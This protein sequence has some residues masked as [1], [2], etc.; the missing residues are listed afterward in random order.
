MG[1]AQE[2]HSWTGHQGRDKGYYGEVPCIPDSDIIV[3]IDG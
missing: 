2:E 3:D 1:P